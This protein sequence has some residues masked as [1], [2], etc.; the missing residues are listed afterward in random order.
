MRN[1]RILTWI[2]NFII[3]VDEEFDLINLQREEL[4]KNNERFMKE[5]K[6]RQE[7]KRKLLVEKMAEKKEKKAP[8]VKKEE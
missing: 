3:I 6:K 5:A 8:E 2:V 1:R 4:I 7:E